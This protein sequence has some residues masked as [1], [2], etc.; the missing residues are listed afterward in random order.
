MSFKNLTI[1]EAL[2][3]QEKIA[4]GAADVKITPTK[5]N[6]L[7]LHICGLLV[8]TDELYSNHCETITY[9][10]DGNIS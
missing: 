6:M 3:C 8:D 1:A 9:L 5:N 4:D 2:K 10:A 7:D